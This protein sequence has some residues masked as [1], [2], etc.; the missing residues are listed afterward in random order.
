MSRKFYGPPRTDF[1]PPP[2]GYI[3]GVGR[4][5]R[6]FSTRS[7]KGNLPVNESVYVAQ[8]GQGPAEI[9]REREKMMAQKKDFQGK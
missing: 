8:R 6:A 4:G 9:K 2:P 1:G 3:P 5:A 7:D